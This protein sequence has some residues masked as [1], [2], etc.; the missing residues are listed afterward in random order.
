MFLQMLAKCTNI[1][2]K[3]YQHSF[4]QKLYAGTLPSTTF[5]FYLQQDKMYLCDFADALL[6]ISEQFDSNKK[7]EYAKQ[8]AELSR[9]VKAAE[10]ELHRDYLQDS[11]SFQFFQQPETETIKIPSIAQYTEHLL[12]TAK[13][14]SI[15]EAVAGVLP[16]FWIY[17]ELG[18]Q[19][20]IGNCSDAHPYRKWIATYS[21]EEFVCKTT[22]IISTLEKLTHSVSCPE[23]Q[24]KIVSSFEKSVNFELMF[25]DETMSDQKEYLSMCKEGQLATSILNSCM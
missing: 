12:F 3:I 16:C 17:S 4:N 20:D 15:E 2:P 18:K 9:Y 14:G 1:F 5:R 25:F 8:F 23:M 13:T 7:E 19:M 21:D 24:E 11:H 10:L 22:A 6:Q